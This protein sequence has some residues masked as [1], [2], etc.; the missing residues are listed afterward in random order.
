MTTTSSQLTSKDNVTP[1]GNRYMTI[2]I[3]ARSQYV[4][5]FLHKTKDEFPHLLKKAIAQADNKIMQQ[6]SHLHQQCGNTLPEKMV[7]TICRGIRVALHD[8]NSPP[9]F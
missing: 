4:M 8:A 9:N 5:I 6:S 1:A 3:I 2:F 7:D